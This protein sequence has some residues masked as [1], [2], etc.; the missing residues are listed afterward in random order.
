[1]CMSSDGTEY[2]TVTRCSRASSSSRRGT[3]VAARGAITQVDPLRAMLK[4]SNVD[5]SKLSGEGQT[6]RSSGDSRKLARRPV[7]EGADRPVRDRHPLRDA[8]GPGGEEDE[9]RVLRRPIA[10]RRG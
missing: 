9:G 2:Q 6:I 3:Q 4:T 1:M 8:G 10:H 5:R 7:H